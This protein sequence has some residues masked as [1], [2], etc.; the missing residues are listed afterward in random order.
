MGQFDLVKRYTEEAYAR[1][2]RVSELERLYIDGRHCYIIPDSENCAVGV[3]ELWTRTYPRDWTGFNNL[4]V[5][6][7]SL[8]QFE[9]AIPVC[10]EALRLNPDH[11]FP[12][13]N[14]IDVYAALGR[15]AEARDIALKAEARGLGELTSHVEAF[16]LAFAL[17]DTAVL[18]AERRWAES[19]ADGF[20]VIAADAEAQ[21][22]TGHARRG[23][24]LYA[25]AIEGAAGRPLPTRLRLTARQAWL[26]AAI[27]DMAEARRLLQSLPAAV[28]FPAAVDAAAA[29]VLAGDRG[30]AES[31][32]A[33]APTDSLP[34]SVRFM[35]TI[36]TVLLDLEKGDRSAG[37]R[38]PPGTGQ[39]LLPFGP[40]LRPVYV[41]GLAYLRAG[42]AADAVAEFQRIVDHP[43][44]APSSPLRP[45]AMVQQARAYVLAADTAAA[46]LQYQNFLAAWKDAD[47]DI[48]ILGEARTE[49]TKLREAAAG[50]GA[51][52]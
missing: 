42:R 6:Y 36:L 37:A 12:Y 3:Y 21:F 50:T 43:G 35:T 28:S 31:I 19:D 39:D 41:R 32:L 5:A 1:R 13:N 25:R 18:A 33:A 38:I 26:D 11:V 44:S 4:C 16:Q 29:A 24:E 23:R 45:L 14:L 7:D 9:K 40:E 17:H 46:R 47:S 34:V 30:R 2:D 49:Y 8:G 10:T 51:H 52:Q 15:L 48:P 27:G 20:A 22:T